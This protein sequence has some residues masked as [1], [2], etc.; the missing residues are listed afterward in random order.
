MNGISFR[1]AAG[2]RVLIDDLRAVRSMPGTCGTAP[3]VIG[4]DDRAMAVGS[5]MEIVGLAAQRPANDQVER[6]GFRSD[7]G[8]ASRWR[9]IS[10][11]SRYHVARP[12]TRKNLSSSV[13][14]ISSTKPLVRGVRT[15]VVR[16][17]CGGPVRASAAP[18]ASCAARDRRNE[19]NCASVATYRRRTRSNAGF[20]TAAERLAA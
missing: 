6:A 19:V 8:K 15:R 7:S 5:S 4:R 12:T 16:C 17:F 14:F 9:R 2:I 13:R 20:G 11:G 10:P 18:R 1:L 3:N